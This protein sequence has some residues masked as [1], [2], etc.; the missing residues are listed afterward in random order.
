MAVALATG[1]FLFTR[2]SPRLA[3]DLRRDLLTDQDRVQLLEGFDGE[4][5][6]RVWSDTSRSVLRDPVNPERDEIALLL[7][8]RARLSW[9]VAA[10]PGARLE[11]GVA[12]LA[13]GPA[14]DA[15]PCALTV[16]VS[17]PGL[18]DV[19]VPVPPAPQDASVP[20]GVLREGPALPVFVDLPEG[21]ETLE[22]FTTADVGDA[23]DS[24]LAVLLSPRV[25]QPPRGVP[26]EDLGAVM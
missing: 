24:K 23:D 26:R 17:G 6:L 25:L 20:E 1:V 3:T 15:A 22:L 16:L 5:R 4:S 7:R 18:L 13:T 12:R 10:R 2:F 19:T 14:E 8:R 21:A 9:Q 11:L